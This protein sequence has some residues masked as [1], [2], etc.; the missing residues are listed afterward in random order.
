MKRPVLALVATLLVLTL[1]ACGAGNDAPTVS[2]KTP[3]VGEKFTISGTVDADGARSALLQEYDEAE[4]WDEAAEAE[5]S[6]AGEYSFTP[7]QDDPVTQYHV[8]AAASG[9]LEK[10]VT[11][12][13]KVATVEDEVH[14]SVV[15][16]GTSG[17]A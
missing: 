7:S 15:R 11:A 1:S 8:V 14:L 2:N 10:H 9:E 16:A 6:A 13:V 5:T 4:G 3:F 12:P 17:T